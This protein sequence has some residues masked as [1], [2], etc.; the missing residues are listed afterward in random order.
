MVNVAVL[1]GVETTCVGVP[2]PAKL[3]AGADFE[4]R[5]DVESVESKRKYVTE[6]A[7][8]GEASITR[9]ITWPFVASKPR[10]PVTACSLAVPF[11]LNRA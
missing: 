11:I 7:L 4:A 1:E 2:L 3:T 9:V 8:V 6:R 10:S 5:G